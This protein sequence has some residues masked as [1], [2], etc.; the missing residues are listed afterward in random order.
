[1]NNYRIVFIFFAIITA[2]VVLPGWLCTQSNQQDTADASTA[3]VFYRIKP[4]QKRRPSPALAQVKSGPGKNFENNAVKEPLAPPYQQLISQAALAYD[5]DA[6]LIRAI[7][8]AESNY[9]SRAVSHRGA[10]GLMQLMPKTAKW[11]GVN[12][13]FDPAMNIDA[14]VRYFKQL[15]D[16]FEGDVQLAL[17][18]YN[19]GGRRVR[20]YGGVPPFGATRAYIKKVLKYQRI[21]SETRT[22]QTVT[23][24]AG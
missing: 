4:D 10:Q 7:I 6:A 11:L 14:G 24:A 17:A 3:T 9:N 12:D 5:V 22:N 16:R 8:M 15:L 19:A 1:M 13:A 23:L 20:E 2:W 18:A 21:F